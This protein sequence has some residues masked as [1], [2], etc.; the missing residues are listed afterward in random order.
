MYETIAW[1][2]LDNLAC[3][4]KSKFSYLHTHIYINSNVSNHAYILAD[5]NLQTRRLTKIR[6]RTL[7]I[8]SLKFCKVDPQNFKEVLPQRKLK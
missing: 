4:T 8:V 5:F 6:T 1:T 2:R 3:I 7:Q